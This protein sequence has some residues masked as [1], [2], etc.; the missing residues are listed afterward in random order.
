MVQM[1]GSVE[2]EHCFSSLAFCESKLCNK[3]TTNPSLMVKM[4]SQKFYTLHNFLYAFAYE[5]WHIK[6]SQYGVGV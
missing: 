1:F 6:H 3:L 5:E 2:D 4:F